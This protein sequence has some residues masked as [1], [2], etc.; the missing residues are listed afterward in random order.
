MKSWV[1][2][3]LCVV[4]LLVVAVACLTSTHV[5][6]KSSTNTDAFTAGVGISW[7]NTD[8]TSM[9]T[10]KPYAGP[11]TTSPRAVIEYGDFITRSS[12][13]SGPRNIP[14]LPRTVIEYADAIYQLSMKRLNGPTVAPRIRVE[15]ADYVGFFYPG[16]H[17]QINATIP[18]KVQCSLNPNPVEVGKSVTLLGNLI[19]TDT[20]MPIP[21]AKITVLLGKSPVGTLTTNSTGWFK[22]VGQVQ[23]PGS[24]NVNCSYAGT[25]QYKPS[26]CLTT[27]IVK[28]QTKIYARVF[29]NPVSPGATTTLEGILITQFS[30]PIKSATI[31]LQYSAN[32]GVTWVSFGNITTNSY[33]IFSKTFTAPTQVGTYTFR[34]T[35]AGSPTLSPSTADALLAVR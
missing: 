7:N 17:P 21:S 29:P 18:T 35:Y 33:G 9:V 20:N 3:Y 27:L 25:T 2:L 23:S 1:L 15:Y 26:Y 16:S 10:Q 22:A 11:K 32:W 34:M 6:A 13:N 19:R 31:S 4:V 12:L 14:I 30:A 8:S 5:D 24:Y 28:A